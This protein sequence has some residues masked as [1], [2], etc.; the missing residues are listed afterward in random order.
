[1]DNC[2]QHKCTHCSSSLNFS[3]SCIYWL[4][5]ICRVDLLQSVVLEGFGTPGEA[6]YFIDKY[7]PCSNEILRWAFHECIKLI[8]NSNGGSGPKFVQTTK[9]A[10]I[11]AALIS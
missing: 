3:H 4:K 6:A 1:M 2:Q 9:T 11:V 5:F 7:N 10:L 8:E